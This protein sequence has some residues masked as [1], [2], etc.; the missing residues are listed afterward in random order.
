MGLTR[1]R[2]TLSSRPAVLCER[3]ADLC[4]R[5]IHGVF[6]DPILMCPIVPRFLFDVFGD[7]SSH[8]L[9]FRAVR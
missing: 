2:H 6:F 1:R 5:S 9:L 8:K 7:L 3:S 4:D